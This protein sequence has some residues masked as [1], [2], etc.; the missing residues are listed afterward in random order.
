[1]AS[2]TVNFLGFILVF[3]LFVYFI[4]FF[5][6]IKIFIS[7]IDDFII[8]MKDAFLGMFTFIETYIVEFFGILY[9]D[10]VDLINKLIDDFTPYF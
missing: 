1:M 3:L 6:M 10:T 2:N 8:Y 5:L 9:K 4:A 7:I